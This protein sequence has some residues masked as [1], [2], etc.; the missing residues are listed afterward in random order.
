MFNLL[1]LKIFWVEVGGVLV[2]EL[3]MVKMRIE[4]LNVL[5]FIEGFFRD[6]KSG[7]RIV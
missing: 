5:L 7:C 1:L 4:I 3:S 6:G 2:N